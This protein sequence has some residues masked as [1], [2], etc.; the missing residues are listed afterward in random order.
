MAQEDI[1]MDFPGV[2]LVTGAGSGIGRETALLYVKEG[3]QRITI[4]DINRV[5]LE[6]TRQQLEAAVQAMVDGTVQQFG[7]IDYCANVAGI[8]VL[9][10]PTDRISTEFY[11]RDHNINLRGLFF[12]ERAELQAMLKQGPLPHKNGNSHS[13]ARGSI[14]NVASMA[15]L[16]GKGAI[17]VYTASKHGVVGLSKADGMYYGQYGIR[18]NTICPGAIATNIL[19]N[20]GNASTVTPL[21]QADKMDNALQ[22]YGDPA[23]VAEA[24]VWITSHRA[25]YITAAVLA[26]NGGQIGV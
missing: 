17:P 13:P 25:S 23:E 3:C 18:V 15:G 7:R 19:R 4:A 22:R 16:V 6:E 11:D 26:V 9:G 1:P 10:P 21:Q 20:S 12:C 2:A 14:V 5:P 24:L 8:T